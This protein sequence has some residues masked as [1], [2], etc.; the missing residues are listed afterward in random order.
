[1][2]EVV[3]MR[4]LGNVPGVRKEVAMPSTY[5]VGELVMHE[6]RVCI[7]KDVNYHGQL[8][9]TEDGGNGVRWIAELSACEE[10]VEYFYVPNY[11]RGDGAVP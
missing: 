7:V 8:I 10:Y 4:L 3:S 1:M 5:K 9:L 2:G 11:W 6:G